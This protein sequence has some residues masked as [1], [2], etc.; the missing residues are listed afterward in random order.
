MTAQI[1]VPFAGEGA[2]VE[3]LTWGQIGFWQGIAEAGR[4]LVMG[5]VTTLPPGL[6]IEDMAEGLRFAVS[7]HQSLRTRLRLDPAGGLPRQACSSSGEVPMEVVDVD[8]AGDPAAVADE[9]LMR[10]EER[11][12]DYEH[13]WPVRMAVIRHDGR[14]THGVVI[15]LHTAI[16]AGGLDVLLADQAARDPR[17]GAA[18]GP[19]TATQPL[20]QARQQ[21]TAAARR[22]CQSSL[23]H[24]EHV[25]RTISLN[26][27]GEPKY[28]DEMAIRLI[29]YHS[30]ATALASKLIAAREHANTSSALLACFAVG[31]AR[32]TGNNPVMAMMLVSNRFRPGFAESVSPLVQV[33]PYLIDVADISLGEAVGR[34]KVSVL[35]T[36]KNAYYDP[37]QQDAVIDRVN[38]E[39]GAEVDMSCFYNDRRRGERG[40]AAGPLPAAD[41]ITAALAGADYRWEHEADPPQRKLYFNVD[42]PPGAIDFAMSVDTR[43]FDDDDMIAVLRGIEA[44]AVQAALEPTA[45]TGVRTPA[46]IQF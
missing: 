14:I 12:F 37:Y 31:L 35:N 38:V 9:V 7:R 45:P 15:Y 23:R 43:Y 39:R 10:Y 22:T 42:D 41:E 25:L 24:L 36:Y 30:P 2:G 5:G 19:V 32:F 26:R 6:T 28:G 16:D 8:A 40:P 1:L 18:K 21:R 11:H 33:S 13:E 29:R 46:S 3:D 44:V 17:T 4:S 27:F 34:A 20:A